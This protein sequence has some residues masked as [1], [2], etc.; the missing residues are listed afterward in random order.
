MGLESELYAR[1]KELR[2]QL[3]IEKKLPAYCIFSNKALEE[4][5]AVMPTSREAFA[6]IYGVG[7]TKLRQYGEK[8]LSEIQ[9]FRE[10][11]GIATPSSLPPFN[12]GREED[13]AVVD[14]PP[15]ELTVRYPEQKA[16]AITIENFEEVKASLQIILASY[17]QVLYTP[18]QLKQAKQDKATLNKLKRAIAAR[19]KEIKDICLEPY[20]NVEAQLKE[21][22]KMID[23]PLE[24][25]SAFT[26]EMTQVERDTKSA[27]IKM[28]FDQEASI[29][30]AAA[31]RVF[32]SGWFYNK[33]WDNKTTPEWVWQN[34]IRQKIEIVAH[35]FSELAEKA[36]D[37]APAVI[38]KFIETGS[39]D[40]ALE[41]LNTI[42]SI[43]EDIGIAGQKTETVIS[44]QPFEAHSQ[45]EEPP[46]QISEMII[47]I[48]GTSAQNQAVLHYLKELG[49]KYEV[50][51]AGD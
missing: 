33:K 20:Y 46:Q 29:L 30:G 42:S 49:V 28:F 41:L 32:S 47:K 13:D 51:V 36:G 10:E 7:T 22:L 35:V 9:R 6:S 19:K 40:Q 45:C 26:A 43:G 24:K 5:A 11:N 4:M 50:F 37:D 16:E 44:S 31:D 17:D 2:Q 39:K 48:I 1:L 34:E 23:F 8:F 12:G 18:D 14:A 15:L 27:T 25:I 3:A 21:L 38:A